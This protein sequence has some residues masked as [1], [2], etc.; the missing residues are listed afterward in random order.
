[1]D[2]GDPRLY[3]CVRTRLERRRPRRKIRAQG[4]DYVRQR[5]ILAAR[6]TARRLG[7]GRRSRQRSGTAQTGEAR[8]QRGRAACCKP[9]RREGVT[10]VWFSLLRIGFVR[11]VRVCLGLKASARGGEHQR[12]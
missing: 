10:P 7:A 2:R 4:G 5:G 9:A 6:T 12:K 3:V 11:V 8:G 1:M